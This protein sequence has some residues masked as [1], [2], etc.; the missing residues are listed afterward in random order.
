MR[1][2]LIASLLPLSAAIF[3]DS[4][5]AADYPFYFRAH[6]GTTELDVS[7][8]Y[9]D[10][11]TAQGFDF[12]WRFLPWLAVEAGYNRLGQFSFE[13]IDDFCGPVS[14]PTIQL[15]STELGLAARFPF[16][17]SK[18][19]GQ[20]RAGLHRWDVGVSGSGHQTDPYYG[21]GIGYQFNPRFS[22]SLNYDRYEAEGF[23]ADRIGLGM[24]IN[25]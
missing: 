18:F 23:D 16:G 14:V 5:R 24:E 21:V 22:L 8:I 12:G 19:Y 4:A 2:L 17:D 25:F 9:D 7:P 1:K 3:S 13:C 15:D 20:V 11:D 10:R 6:V